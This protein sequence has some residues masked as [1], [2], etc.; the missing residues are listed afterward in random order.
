MKRPIDADEAI[1]HFRRII[2]ATNTDSGYNEGFI[3]ALKFCIST[4]STM[5]AA[6][7]EPKTTHWVPLDERFASW[8]SYYKCSE[9]GFRI[10][11]RTVMDFSGQSVD[12]CPHC[13]LRMEGEV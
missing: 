5:P 4:L 9:C 1:D 3:D 10:N 7:P 8:S 2:D 6:Q 13:G 12:Y 11:L